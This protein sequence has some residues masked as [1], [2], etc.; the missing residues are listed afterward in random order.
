MS[1]RKITVMAFEAICKAVMSINDMYNVSCT[2][3]AISI[4]SH[5]KHESFKKIT[6]NSELGFQDLDT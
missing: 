2:D 1:L 4:C 3:F 6:K 5:C